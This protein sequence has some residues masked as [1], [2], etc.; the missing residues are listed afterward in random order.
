MSRI[1]Q[2]SSTEVRNLDQTMADVRKSETVRTVHYPTDPQAFILL[3][4]MIGPATTE[5]RSIWHRRSKLSSTYCKSKQEGGASS[6]PNDK[7][8]TLSRAA[9]MS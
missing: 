1:S 6:L 3:C 5:I 8:I 4:G 9:V 2:R 7:S